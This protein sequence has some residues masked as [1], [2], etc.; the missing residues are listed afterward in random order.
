MQ[1]ESPVF[2]A[3]IVSTAQARSVRLAG[4]RNP[5]GAGHCTCRLYYISRKC[6]DLPPCVN[7]GPIGGFSSA[8]HALQPRLDPCRPEGAGLPVERFSRRNPRSRG[9]AH[10]AAIQLAWESPG[11]DGQAGT[12]H[13]FADPG[14]VHGDPPGHPEARLARWLGKIRQVADAAAGLLVYNEPAFRRPGGPEWGSCM[15]FQPGPEGDS[16]VPDRSGVFSNAS[17]A[18]SH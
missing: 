14:P 4:E 12:C 15:D 11:P 6:A 17:A 7:R 1:I 16:R 2:I 5:K 10:S 9:G 13:G 3:L 18:E 8:W